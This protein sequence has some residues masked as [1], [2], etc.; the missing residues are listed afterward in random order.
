MKKILKWGAIIFVGLIVIGVIAGMGKSGNNPTSG[1]NQSQN[2]AEQ[3]T[4]APEAM[5]ISATE[6]ADDFDGNQVAAEK[7]WSGKL[8]EFTAEVSNITDSGLSFT[9]VASKEFSFAQISCKVKDKN[10]LLS[11]KNGEM[12]TVR[13]VVGKQTIGVI[14]VSDC[15]VVK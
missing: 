3:P 14:D 7:K 6:L 12:A 9:K 13:G 5:K 11:L 4:Q 2:Q 8:V 10:Q 1:S 15:E